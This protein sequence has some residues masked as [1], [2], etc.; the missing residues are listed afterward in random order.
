MSHPELIELLRRRLRVIADHDLRERDPETQLRMLREVSE[1]ID[2]YGESHRGSF[3][4][5]LRHFLDGCSFEKAL[6]H[7]ESGSQD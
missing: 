7:L 1:A 2:A 6:Q 3:D 5:R 4:A